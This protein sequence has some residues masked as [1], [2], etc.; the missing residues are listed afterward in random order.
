LRQL[1]SKHVKQQHLS[2]HSTIRMMTVAIMST[3]P[4]TINAI[5]HGCSSIPSPSNVHHHQN[6]F[7]GTV[8]KVER[9][10]GCFGDA[11]CAKFNPLMGTGNYSATSNNEKLLHWPLMGELLHLVQRVGDWAGLQPADAPPC[12]TKYN[13]PLINGHIAK[14]EVKVI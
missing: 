12:C 5:C 3:P 8:H 4:T 2:L 1:Q 14:Q 7:T 10:L 13:S 6:I 11:I 9:K